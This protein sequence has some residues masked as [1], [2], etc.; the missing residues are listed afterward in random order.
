MES[1]PPITI[2]A[3]DTVHLCGALSP[4]ETEELARSGAYRSWLFLNSQADAD[5][6][7][8]GP[9]VEAAG[10][11]FS[12]VEVDKDQL[13]VDLAE[14]VVAQ[15]DAASKP[16]LIQC[17]TATR[18]GAVLLL[19]LAKQRGLNFA[20]A[21]QLGLDMGLKFAEGHVPGDGSRS[22]NGPEAD[23]DDAPPPPNPPPLVRWVEEALAGSEIRSR[24]DDLLVWQLFDDAG[25]STYTYLLADAATKDAV[26]ID[27]VLEQ[28]ERDLATIDAEGLTLRYVINTHAH[29]DHIT[30]SGTIKAQRPGVQSVIAAASGAVA[31]VKVADGDEISFGSQRLVTISTPGH[32]EGCVR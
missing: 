19:S 9:A 26:L 31:D 30:G 18:A 8:V 4:A 27:P 32:T 1:T 12:I 10:L 17:S 13:S 2:A 21:M 22:S 11:A 5:E 25:S 16:C 3:T 14:R 7:G 20:A 23:S 6:A 29:A 15:L 28:V 24:S